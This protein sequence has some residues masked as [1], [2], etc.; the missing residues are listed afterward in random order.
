MARPSPGGN[1]YLRNVLNRV[2]EIAPN[3]QIRLASNRL[4]MLDVPSL[5]TPLG[6][7]TQPQRH[8][9]GE[10][11]TGAVFDTLVEVFQQNLVDAGLITPEIDALSRRGDRPGAGGDQ[12]QT[13]FDRAYAAQPGE[14]ARALREARDYMGVLLALTWSQLKWDLSFA[15]V[16]RAMLRAD[17]KL[18]GG[19]FQPEIL[20]SLVWREIGAFDGR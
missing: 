4:R 2:G 3:E 19:Y 6:Q 1:L 10:P 7:L 13:A 18:S 8:R 11:L 12:V 15:D 14:F 16:G 5:D 17:L 20:E 9:I